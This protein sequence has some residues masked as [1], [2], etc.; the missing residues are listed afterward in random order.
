M[1]TT[2]Q[3]QE[4]FSY[5]VIPMVVIGL[6]LLAYVIYRIVEFLLTRQKKQK[7]EIAAKPVEKVVDLVALRQEYLDKVVRLEMKYKA[8]EI[9]TR[10]AYS[11]L[12]S[13]FRNFVYEAT[14]VEAPKYTLHD[15]QGLNMPVLYNLVDNYYE[16]EFSE[17]SDRNMLESIDMTKRAIQLWN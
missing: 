10:D 11:E 3:L 9:E 2:V 1:E 8:E 5:S 12:S 6:L 7:E 17:K 14:G 16:P 13:I 15:I 4:P